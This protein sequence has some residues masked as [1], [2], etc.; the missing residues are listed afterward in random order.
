MLEELDELEVLDVEE[1]ELLDMEGPPPVPVDVVDW[2]LPPPRSWVRL[3]P[4]SKAE[5]EADSGSNGRMK[6]PGRKGAR[7]RAVV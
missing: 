1:E 4:R 2:V 3:Q 5:S 6:P 7:R